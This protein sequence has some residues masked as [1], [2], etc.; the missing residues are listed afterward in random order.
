[1]IKTIVVQQ[2]HLVRVLLVRANFLLRNT[3][4]GRLREQGA[5]ASVFLTSN[6]LLRDMGSSYN[7]HTSIRA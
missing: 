6:A 1:M 5:Y 2:T 3:Q 4:T 7:S